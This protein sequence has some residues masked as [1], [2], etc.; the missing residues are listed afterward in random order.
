M[1]ENKRYNIKKPI[2]LK[3]KIAKKEKGINMTKKRF[4]KH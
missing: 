2:L 1:R 4:A 3:I